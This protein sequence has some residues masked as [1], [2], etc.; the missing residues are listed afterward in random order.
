MYLIT[1]YYTSYEKLKLYLLEKPHFWRLNKTN[2]FDLT[3]CF[4][5]I[6]IIIII[7]LVTFAPGSTNKQQTLIA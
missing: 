1:L 6:S 3:F 4:D 2:S 7:I 5:K